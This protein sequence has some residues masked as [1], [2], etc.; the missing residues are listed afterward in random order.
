M[1]ASLLQVRT[2]FGSPPSLQL[3]DRIDPADGRVRAVR[4][5]SASLP[6]AARIADVG[7][8]N[9][10]FLRHLARWFPDARLTGI[11]LSAAVLAD[12]PAGVDALRGSLLRIPAG[13][14]TFDG[15]FA[16]E[17]LEHALF[18]VRAVAELCRIVRPGGRVLIIDK[19]RR[20]QSLSEH[21]PW[22]RWFT[23]GELAGWLS[24]HCD[25]VTVEPVSHL[26]GRGGNNLF[27]AAQGRRR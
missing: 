3:P 20:R 13:D 7:C 24:A 2:A 22:E 15:A 8:G 5:W 6:A 26:E 17:S 9:G 11:D 27:L 10:R 4:D 16:V 1:D 21:Q 18:P 23:P 12:L 25:E 14:G 19:N